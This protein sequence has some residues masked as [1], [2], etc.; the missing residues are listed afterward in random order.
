MVMVDVKKNVRAVLLSMKD[1]VLASDFASDYLSLTGGD[2]QVS[3]VR[4]RVGSRTNV[5]YT[6]HGLGLHIG[7]PDSVPCCR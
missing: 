3:V 2:T 6:R 7:R 5:C 4:V 1:G